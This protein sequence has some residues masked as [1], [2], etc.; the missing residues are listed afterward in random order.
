MIKDVHAAIWKS[1]VNYFIGEKPADVE[2]YIRDVYDLGREDECTAEYLDKVELCYHNEIGGVCG[3]TDG[4]DCFIYVRSK[5]RVKELVH[6]SN[7]AVF[8]ILDKCGLTLSYETQEA[9]CYLLEYLIGEIL[10]KE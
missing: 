3:F 2:K 8:H 10:K 7:H 9:Y 1:H 6:E 5:N 4:M